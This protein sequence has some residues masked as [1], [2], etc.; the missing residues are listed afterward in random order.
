MT[1]YKQP[2]MNKITFL[3]AILIS[4]FGIQAQTLKAKSSVKS[5][6]NKDITILEPKQGID[7]Y[8]HPQ[9]NG[10]YT[11]RIKAMVLMRNL[12][13]SLKMVAKGSVL[14]DL[15][16]AEVG[17]LKE[18]V[19]CVQMKQADGRKNK[20]K[21]LIIIEGQAFKTQFENNSIPEEALQKL[22]SGKKR[23][24]VGKEVNN[25]VSEWGLPRTDHGDFTFYPIYREH[26]STKDRED[27]KILLVYKKGGSF[28]GIVTHGFSMDIEAKM[29]KADDPFYFYFPV[30]KATDRDFK[31]IFDLVFEFIPL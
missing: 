28:Y 18:E 14:Y 29:E 11:L 9:G 27:F 4:G 31:A 17:T 20:D 25:L 19:I 12:D 22:F 16:G 5:P 8:S 13:D 6:A 10:W 2:T 3:L 15:D 23:G 26:Y 30:M 21:Y 1:Y 24:M 7:V